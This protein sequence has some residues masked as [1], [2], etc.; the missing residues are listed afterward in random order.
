MRIS[1]AIH[2]FT[3]L[4]LVSVLANAQ[5]VEKTLVKSFN[6]QGKQSVEEK[7]VSKASNFRKISLIRFL[8]QKM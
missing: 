6:L 5:N 4:M 7:Y 8:S 2:I 3:G 1:K